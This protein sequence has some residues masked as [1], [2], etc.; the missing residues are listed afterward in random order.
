MRRIAARL[1]P[2]G[3]AA[4]PVAARPSP[5]RRPP[6]ALAGPFGPARACPVTASSCRR[7]S[8]PKGRTRPAPAAQARLSSWR[9]RHADGSC[10]SPAQPAQQAAR[11]SAN[12]VRRRDILCQPAQCRLRLHPS[13]PAAGPAA[14]AVLLPA[15]AT[16]CPGSPAPSA[17]PP[18]SLDP[19]YRYNAEPTT[20]SPGPAAA[21]R[22][23]HRQRP[24]P[25]APSH[26]A[27][28]RRPPSAPRPAAARASHSPP[29]RFWRSGRTRQ[30]RP[31]GWPRWSRLRR[32][33]WPGSSPSGTRPRQPHPSVPGTTASLASPPRQ[34]Q[35]PPALRRSDR[36]SA[37]GA[38]GHARRAGPLRL[39]QK[40]RPRGLPPAAGAGGI[41]AFPRRAGP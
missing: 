1:R 41:R 21:D 36:R 37:S 30:S 15:C 38:A 4:L 31:S 25:T 5:R 39:R 3:I 6:S 17:V 2:A 13:C 11:P 35:S 8:C 29:A 33:G 22:P 24:G 40:C 20:A 32:S 18:A 26:Q 7:T 28:P 23:H 9:Y 12:S 19:P 10:R 34:P 16:D 27:G 14:R